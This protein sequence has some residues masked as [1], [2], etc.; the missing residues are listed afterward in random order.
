[1]AADEPAKARTVMSTDVSTLLPM[2]G[3]GPR[4]RSL[5][6]W[7]DVAQF[8]AK[9]VCVPG[10][11]TV[12]TQRLQ[13]LVEEVRMLHS[14]LHRVAVGLALSEDLLA[15][16]LEQLATTPGRDSTQYRLQ[17]NRARVAAQEC[18]DF[19]KRLDELDP[20]NDTSKP[21]WDNPFPE[22]EGIHLH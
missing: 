18:R 10:P 17:A 3:E 11:Q 4:S 8:G 22:N 20:G 13:H 6:W 19:A 21:D 9:T 2:F 5:G 1:M 7:I 12:Q 15:V 14:R 16:T